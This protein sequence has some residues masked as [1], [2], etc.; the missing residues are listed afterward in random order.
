MS[1]LVNVKINGLPI[2][3]PKG[4]RIIEAARML[5]IDI[6]HLCYHPDQTIKAHCRMCS[7][8]VSGNSKLHPGVGGHGGLDRD[9]E[10][11]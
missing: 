10:G 4:T 2:A 6:P 9:Q 8:E 5:H 1:E 3:V 11:L 7:V